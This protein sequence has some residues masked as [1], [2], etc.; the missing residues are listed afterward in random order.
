M[1]KQLTLE[2]S[3]DEMLSPLYLLCSNLLNHIQIL[4]YSIIKN[5]GAPRFLM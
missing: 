4:K 5:N 2:S 1:K 3:V